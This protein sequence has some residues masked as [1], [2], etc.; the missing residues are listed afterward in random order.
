VYI[1]LDKIGEDEVFVC[2]KFD[3][4]IQAESYL[5]TSGNIRYEVKK[6]YG[7]CKFNKQTE[8]FELDKEK[9][10]PYFTEK[11]REVI[12]VHCNLISRKRET[13][14]YPEIIDIATPG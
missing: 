13:L 11:S 1:K 2:Y 12:K 9:T 10:D 14:G 6:I 5:S 8:E 3:I 7:Y 4:S